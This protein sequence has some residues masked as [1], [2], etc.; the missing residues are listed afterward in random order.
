MVEVIMKKQESSPK[1]QE[2]GSVIT[3][4]ICFRSQKTIVFQLLWLHIPCLDA[5]K[6]KNHRGFEL[7]LIIP[8]WI[9]I[10]I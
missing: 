2:E 9:Y 5:N 8:L 1:R 7:I 10:L 6:N 4:N 3:K